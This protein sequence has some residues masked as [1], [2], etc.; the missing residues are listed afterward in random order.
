M[1]Y[2]IRT[3]EGNNLFDA[4]VSKDDLHN[5]IDIL[6][7]SEMLLK[8]NKLIQLEFMNDCADLYEIRGTYWELN[9]NK[10][11]ND[12]VNV[13]FNSFAKKWNLF[14]VTD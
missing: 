7:F 3:K 5:A 8:F 14:V 6:V 12:F 1:T 2:Y 10:N 4:E 9:K 13:V 11:I